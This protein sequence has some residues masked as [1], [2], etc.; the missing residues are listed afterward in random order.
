MAE[1]K[2]INRV[3]TGMNE[4]GTVSGFPSHHVDPSIKQQPEWCLRFLKGMHTGNN[5]NNIFR[6]KSEDYKK[7]RDYARGQQEIDQYKE[8]RAAGKKRNRGKNNN[9]WKN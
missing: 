8:R 7:W 5:E 9:T 4:K 1:V 6:N 3:N 2:N